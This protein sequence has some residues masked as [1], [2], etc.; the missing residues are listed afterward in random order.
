MLRDVTDAD[1]LRAYE[2]LGINRIAPDQNE[3]SRARDDV[4]II[5]SSDLL[6]LAGLG[7]RPSLSLT[8]MVEVI[9]LPV[10]VEGPIKAA[11]R[12]CPEEGRKLFFSDLAKVTDKDIDYCIRYRGIGK[13]A[14]E[15]ILNLR[16][17][18]L[19]TGR[20]Q[21]LPGLAVHK[22]VEMGIPEQEA[23]I[24]RIA[25]CIRRDPKARRTLSQLFP[26]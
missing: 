22:H 15:M 6:A 25:A 17:I 3:P 19:E 26:G 23:L 8:E 4:A 12:N 24:E 1:A 7:C 5:L 16:N 21:N 13:H 9:N 20:F 18:Y 10:Q 2:L 14:V 11:S